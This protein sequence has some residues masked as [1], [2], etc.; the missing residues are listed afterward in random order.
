MTRRCGAPMPPN[1]LV[2]RTGRANLRIETAPNAVIKQLRPRGLTR[3][4][5]ALESL[6]SRG[7]E[8]NRHP[9]V[10]HTSIWRRQASR[11]RNYLME[12]TDASVTCINH[13]KHFTAHGAAAPTPNRTDGS[14][15]E[16]HRCVVIEK[17]SSDEEI[18]G[19]NGTLVVIC[20][21]WP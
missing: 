7:L 17:G 1:L 12:L 13:P 2:R 10:A 6:A 4:R 19:S 21:R 20:L 5:N 16:L 11:R 8:M 14:I 18:L 9:T 15:A 3:R